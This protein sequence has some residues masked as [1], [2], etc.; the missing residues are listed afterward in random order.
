MSTASTIHSLISQHDELSRLLP[1]ISGITIIEY[2]VSNLAVT[3]INYREK[4]QSQLSA[5]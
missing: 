4:M 5:M 3:T 1:L 2:D